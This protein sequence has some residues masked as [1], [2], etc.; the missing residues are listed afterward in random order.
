MHTPNEQA[1]PAP[2]SEDKLQQIYPTPKTFDEIYAEK[3]ERAELFDS[4]RPKHPIFMT[5]FS[6]YCVLLFALLLA[7]V[8]PDMIGPNPL[9]GVSF[10]FLFTIIWLGFARYVV[11]HITSD[12]HSLGLNV[13]GMYMLYTITGIAPLVA[14]A[15]PFLSHPSSLSTVQYLVL[16]SIW[17]CFIATSLVAVALRQAKNN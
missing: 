10:A 8:I 5:A 12:L 11:G 4:R 17:H 16:A 7:V 2:L 6:S 3:A 15:Y 14:L 13:S 9:S 1:A